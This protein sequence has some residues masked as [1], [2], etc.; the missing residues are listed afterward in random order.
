[1]NDER[2]IGQIETARGK[3]EGVRKLREY[4]RVALSSLRMEGELGRCAVRIN[5]TTSLKDF[6]ERF[7]EL[8]RAMMRESQEW[9]ALMITNELEPVT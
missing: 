3:V 9:L 2:Q 1:M 4:S 7:R 8:D 5:A 6:E